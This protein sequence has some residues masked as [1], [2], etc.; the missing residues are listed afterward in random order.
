VFARPD[1]TLALYAAITRPIAGREPLYKLGQ[2]MWRGGYPLLRHGEWEG[3]MDVF[4]SDWALPPGALASLAA[5]P[6]RVAMLLEAIGP[7][8]RRRAG[9]ILCER[10]RTRA[11]EAPEAEGD[12]FLRLLLRFLLSRLPAA[13]FGRSNYG[14]VA[15]P[16]AQSTV[17][18]TIRLARPQG[19]LLF[20]HLGSNV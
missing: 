7:S 14:Q 17:A 10:L 19:G 2:E 12:R 16:A 9:A 4:H 15:V 5:S 3:W 18:V 13:R 11:L 20:R 6:H 8:C 1:C